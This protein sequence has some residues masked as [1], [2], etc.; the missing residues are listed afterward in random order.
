MAAKSRRAAARRLT[1]GA[2]AALLSAAVLVSSVAGIRAVSMCHEGSFFSVF[3]AVNRGLN[4]EASETVHVLRVETSEAQRT[5]RTSF[6]AAIFF[7]QFSILVFGWGKREGTVG[8][9]MEA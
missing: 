9:P 3:S 7:A 1:K 8:G 6:V 5:R 2:A 4:T